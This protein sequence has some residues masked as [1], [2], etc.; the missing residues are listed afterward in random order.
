[1]FGAGHV[2][3]AV[4]RALAPLPF[5]LDWFDSRPEFAPPAALADETAQLEAIGLAAP[6]SLFLI[7]THS[8]ALDYALTR[9]V[10]RRGDARYCGLIGSKTKRARFVARLAAEGLTDAGLTCPIGLAALTSKAP[11]VIAVGVAAQLLMLVQAPA[12]SEIP[13]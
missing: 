7:F 12:R 9:A 11:E 13:A 2:G 1:M 3:Q 5:Q 10:L 8:H 4:A 6:Q